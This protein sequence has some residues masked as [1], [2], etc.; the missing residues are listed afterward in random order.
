MRRVLAITLVMAAAVTVAL[1]GTGASDGGSDYR[2]RVIFDNGF[3]LVKG[4]DVKVAGVKVGKIAELDV[5]DDNRAAAV[6]AIDNADF[7]DFR[8]DAKCSIRPQSLIG[9]RY[10]ECTL[11]EP[12]SNGGQ[13]P[14]EL[15]KVP[16]GQEG[17]GEYLLPVERTSKPVDADLL[18]N[19][20]R[21][22]QR[23][24][25]AIIVNELG[26]G[27]AGRSEDLNET[28]RRANPA[29]KATND[30]IKI[31]A[32]QNDVL[33]KLAEDSDRVLAPLARDRAQVADFIEQANTVSRAT[34]ERQEPFERGFELLPRFLSEL[35]P[36]MN[37]LGELSDE[38]APVLED[39]QSVAPDINRFFRALGPFSEAS[40]PAFET[41]GDAA[42]EG[43][44][45][46]IAAKPI[47]D[48][49]KRLT[50]EARPLADNLA[51]LTES[52]RDSG[53]IERLMDYL[54]YQVAAINGYDQYG[55][56]LRAGLIV[57]TCTTYSVTPQPGC[58]A[59]WLAQEDNESRAAAAN[60]A[61]VRRAFA[62]RA[63]GEDHSAAAMRGDAATTRQAPARRS[64]ASRPKP[65]LRMPK[66][67][68][69]GQDTSGTKRWKP[70]AAQRR[71]AARETQDGLL[72]YLLGGGS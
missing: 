72:D 68:L 71:Q 25:L 32:E 45:A 19:V 53:G 12:R 65:A 16:D 24:R 10:I 62:A 13:P 44:P 7:Q 63:A 64:T 18:N 33:A 15:G 51:E 41:L 17:E 70:T 69:P 39:L 57:N 59:K 8:Q 2:V 60:P 29:L 30:V 54:F 42:E 5:T 55:H 3:A 43:R 22:P 6:L 49:L 1:L 67:V 14:P 34:A 35:R 66:A 9:E 50:D 11:T 56:Y 36:T 27:L 37:R 58:S 26:A 28:I 52:L 20:L 21:L 47:I 46:L 4:L 40:I 31:L 38:F 48:D 23:Q 61:N